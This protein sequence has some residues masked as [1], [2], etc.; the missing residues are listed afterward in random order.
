MKLSLKCDSK[1]FLFIEDSSKTNII[2]YQSSEKDEMIDIFR[3]DVDR[4]IYTNDDVI[5][6]LFMNVLI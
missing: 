5:I 6:L 3:T 4:L 2:H 1:V